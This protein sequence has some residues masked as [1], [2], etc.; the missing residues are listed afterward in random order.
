VRLLRMFHL[1]FHLAEDAVCCLGYFPVC[2]AYNSYIV[3][4]LAIGSCTADVCFVLV[5][6]LVYWCISYNI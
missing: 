2:G 3:R 5:P 4:F 6:R 1:M